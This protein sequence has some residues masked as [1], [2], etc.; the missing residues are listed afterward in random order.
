MTAA[1]ITGMGIVCAIGDNVDQLGHALKNGA[2]G[3]NVLDCVDDP[4]LKKKPGAMIRDFSLKDLV[5]RYQSLPSDFYRNF[6]KATL[7]AP[8]GIQISALTALEA[9]ID[10][11]LFHDPPDPERVGLVVGGNNLNQ[12]F[13]YR[14]I[15]KFR[16]TPEYLTPRYPL[17]FM[18]TDHVGTVSEIFSIRGE[19]FSV[20]GA[21]ASGAMALVKG[22]QLI[23]A[24]AVDACMVIGAL[25]DLSPLE[26]QGFCNI[27]AMGGKQFKDRPAEACRPFDCRH[28]GFIYGQGG[29]C[30]IIESLEAQKKRGASSRAYVAGGSIALDG[31]RLSDPNV[32]GE[33]RAMRRA[34]ADA[35]IEPSAVDYINTH[36][37]SSPLG[38]DTEVKAVKQVFADCVSKPW[39]NSTKSLAGHCL[40]AAG[41]VES[42]AT[43][44]QMSDGFVHP[45]LNLDEP[46]D[47][48]LRFAGNRA[49][50]AAI[51][52]ALKNSF[53]FGGINTSLVF[54]K[55][56]AS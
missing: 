15:D 12:R 54:R 14:Q 17:H 28:E 47:R 7:R 30:I 34:L 39:I 46:I 21:S 3:I 16:K 2:C 19:G 6:L 50:D 48:Q 1:A 38:D 9:W 23:R 41:M 53:G 10:A 56:S 40:T 49:E 18:D 32:D 24:G 42:I 55:K 52:V 5:G 22:L 26:I 4:I 44:I 11:G 27:G 35:G 51:N 43:V 13:C 36:G 29:G 31:N 8:L 25:A 37:T 45:N 20:G 33:T